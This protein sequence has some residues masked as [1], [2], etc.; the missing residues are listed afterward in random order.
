[1]LQRKVYVSVA[2]RKI[3]DCLDLPPEYRDLLTTDDGDTNLHAVPLWMV[4]Q[5]HMAKLLKHYRGRFST[6]VGFQ[7]TGWTHQRD[8]GQTRARGRR[9]QKGTIIT[10]QASAALGRPTGASGKRRCNTRRPPL[11]PSCPLCTCCPQV[12]Y[13]EHSSFSELQEF[14][15]WFAPVR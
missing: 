2:K 11:P 7:P 3:L 9:R 12:P 5:K 8:A 4:S 15:R 14:V 10:Y 1:V 6:A 13:S